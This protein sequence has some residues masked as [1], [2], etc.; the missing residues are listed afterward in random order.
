M[1]TSRTATTVAGLQLRPGD[2]VLS[3]DGAHLI[4]HFS[5][6]PGRFLGRGGARVAHDANGTWQRTVAD[7]QNFHVVAYPEPVPAL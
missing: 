4:D 7:C 6:Y 2:T 1:N 3:L 5:A